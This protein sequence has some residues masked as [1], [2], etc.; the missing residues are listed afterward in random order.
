MSSNILVQ[1]ICQN[2]NTEFTAKTTVTK[3]CSNNCAKNAW[4]KRKQAGKVKKINRATKKEVL[5]E[6]TYDDSINIFDYKLNQKR[7]YFD[8]FPISHFQITLRNILKRTFFRN[9]S[10]PYFEMISKK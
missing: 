9:I 5:F 8:I 7:T 10:S 2:C 1:R 3:Y 4:R 6:K